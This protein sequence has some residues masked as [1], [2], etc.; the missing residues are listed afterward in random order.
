[1]VARKGGRSS[2]GRVGRGLGEAGGGAGVEEVWGGGGGGGGRGGGGGGWGVGGGGG[3][4]LGRAGA[5]PG[6]GGGGGELYGGR[7]VGAARRVDSVGS[8][9]RRLRKTSI[10]A[11]ARASISL[12]I[13]PGQ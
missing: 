8:G 2:G 10:G 4:G 13:A 11:E 12:R 7:W 9:G 3:G 6:E 1:M 5:G